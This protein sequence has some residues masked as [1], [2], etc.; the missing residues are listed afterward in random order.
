MPVTHSPNGTHPVDSSPSAQP[1]GV[2]QGVPIALPPP[3]PENGTIRV[4]PI[5]SPRVQPNGTSP[6][7]PA[8]IA[9]PPPPSANGTYS[10]RAQPNGVSHP[11]PVR[12]ALPAPHPANGTHPVHD[13]PVP[14]KVPF[15]DLKI[16]CTRIDREKIATVIRT[17]DE[18]H[19]AGVIGNTVSL[20]TIKKDIF[21]VHSLAFLW[22]IFSTPDLK[23]RMPNIF[24]RKT[25][26][27]GHFHR[28]GFMDGVNEGMSR[29]TLQKVKPYLDSWA[30]ELGTTKQQVEPLVAKGFV[31][32]NWEELVRHLMSL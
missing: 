11:I 10:P 20:L 5:L 21:H 6:A 17:L 31:N 27:F 4:E 22:T 12:I 23:R 30:R 8:R 26:M 9:L 14:V 13:A 24:E 2:I 32:K 19:M 29:Y 7:I 1:N 25:F 18:N 3:Q 15:D 28:K 16:E